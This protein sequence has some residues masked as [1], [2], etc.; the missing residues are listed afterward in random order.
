M[1]GA[2]DGRQLDPADGPAE[3]EQAARGNPASSDTHGYSCPLRAQS[4]DERGDEDNQY[5]HCRS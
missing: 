1:I 4:N 5:E 3:H 2:I